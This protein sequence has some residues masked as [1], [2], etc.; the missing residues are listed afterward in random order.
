VQPH[1]QQCPQL[2]KH[3]R[4]VMR[5]RRHQISL[6][7]LPGIHGGG[8]L[9]GYRKPAAQPSVCWWSRSSWAGVSVCPVICHVS[10]PAS[11]DEREQAA[12][13]GAGAAPD[14]RVPAAA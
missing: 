13:P 9:A 6:R 3:R 7:L 4:L 11:V 10:V 2:L 14:R 1:A 8:I 12:A 5:L